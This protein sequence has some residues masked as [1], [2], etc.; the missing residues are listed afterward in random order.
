MLKQRIITALILVF[1]VLLALF[2][3][4]PIYWRILITAVVVT[5]FWEWLRFC[6]IDNPLLNIVSYVVFAAACYL[7]QIGAVPISLAVPLVCVLWAVLIFFTL[8]QTLNILHQPLIKLSLGIV[9]LSVSGW[10]II[11]LKSIEHGALWV[12]AFL[13]SVVFAD[14]GAYF[15]GRR[16][17]KT[18]LAP[19]VSPG[20]TVEGLFGGLALVSLIFIPVMFSLFSVKTALLLLV[21]VLVTALVSVAGDLFESK[22]KR[23]AGLKDSSQILPGHGGIMDR[24]D[25]IMAGGPFFALGLIVLGYL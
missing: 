5:G 3:S 25:S 19:T 1:I 22:L 21:T 2:A 9:L 8:T 23:H 20:K 10:V 12:V 7:F 18:K 14:I 6:E 15:V 16:F 17:G 11:E 13:C 4:N 24:I